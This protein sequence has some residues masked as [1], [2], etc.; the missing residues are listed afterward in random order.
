MNFPEELPNFFV[1]WPGA[2]DRRQPLISLTDYLV[3]MA[4]ILVAK[5]QEYIKL[6]KLFNRGV[7]CKSLHTRQETILSDTEQKFN[8]SIVIVMIAISNV[9]TIYTVQLIVSPKY[10]AKYREHC[11]HS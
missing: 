5:R 6:T 10:M 3:A 7:P 8:T 9:I 1:V 4:I 2:S 11:F